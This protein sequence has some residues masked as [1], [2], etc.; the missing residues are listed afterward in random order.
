MDELTPPSEDG[1]GDL[2]FA[3][4]LGA[5]GAGILLLAALL[6]SL[7]SFLQGGAGLYLIAFGITAIFGPVGF[8]LLG[9]AWRIRNRVVHGSVLPP[10]HRRNLRILGAL[11]LASGLFVALSGFG[12]SGAIS[13]ALNLVWGLTLAVYGVRSL[14]R[15]FATDRA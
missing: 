13:T 4:V 5:M 15:S 12:A 2:G 9:E 1:R 10:A 6:L 14:L 11:L 7:P 8:W 3:R